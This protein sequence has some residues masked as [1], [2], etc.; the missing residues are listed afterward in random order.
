[1][2]I[3]IWI[4]G[5]QLLDSHPALE[6]SAGDAMRVVLVE[7]WSRAR[8][9][10]YHRHKITLIFS[11]MRHYAE[12][13]RARGLDVDYRTSDSL[14]D[15]LRSAA[16][17]FAPDRIVTM[18]ASEYRGRRFQQT[19]LADVTGVP[20]EVLPNT[21]FLVGQFD[22]FADVPRGK[23][24]VMEYFYRAMRRRF[25]ILMD[26]D[27]PVGGQWNYDHDNR[28]PLPRTGIDI[29]PLIG[30]PPDALT[31]E[32]MRAVDAHGHGLGTTAGFAYAVTHEQA[33]AALTAFVTERLPHFGTYEDAMTASSRT[34]FHSVLS[35]Y[36]NLGLLTP[37]EMVDAA[38]RAY[39]AGDAPLNAVEGFVRQVIG[40]REYMVWQY[41]RQMPDLLDA[42]AWSARR[43]VP[44]F[45]WSGQTDMNC[46]KHAL[47]GV[48]ETGY[49]HH[50]E[51]LMLISNYF[52]LCGVEPQAAV[53]WFSA[54]FVDA[55]DWVMQ[56][57]VVGMGL[58]ADGGLTATKPYIAS[59]NYIHK[60]GDY[61]G[62]C[63][64]DHRARTGDRAC[65]FNTLYWQ[66][67]ITHEQRLRAN[68]R[69]GKAVLGLRHLDDDERARV[70]AQARDYLEG[71]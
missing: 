35:P 11:A 43:P 23:A 48:L 34:V 20:V 52:M 40:W 61:C 55:Y 70:S 53:S 33:R 18:A 7:N 56:P 64:Y 1:M 37:L 44:D 28:Q 14:S 66:F 29:P 3:L 5:D 54:A 47:S 16:Q 9:L 60:M 32:V 57:N 6:H 63:R 10:P 21:Q 17:D 4:P 41:W 15:S 68:P 25:D 13:L 59:A 22:P 65:P 46:L 42:N 31:R 51:R 45:F 39:H 2:K 58:N 26:G 62:A 8:R 19:R 36:V 49:A 24:T 67:L 38:V 50:I 27:Q 71:L 69:A 30:F 12:R